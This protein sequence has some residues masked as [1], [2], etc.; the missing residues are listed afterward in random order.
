M[1]PV[2]GHH[3]D[4]DSTLLPLP[5]SGTTWFGDIFARLTPLAAGLYMK[6]VAGEYSPVLS[7]E[8]GLQQ[9]CVR[10]IS[11]LRVVL[12]THLRPTCMTNSSSIVRK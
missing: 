4:S 11:L 2:A 1:M 5:K 12:P 6:E 9:S 3:S 10:R 8:I 7:N